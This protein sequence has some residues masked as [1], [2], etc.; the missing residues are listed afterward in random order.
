MSEAICPKCGETR[1]SGTYCLRCGIIFERYRPR[2]RRFAGGP[3]D[4]APAETDTP[5]DSRRSNE[6]FDEGPPSGGEAV[7]GVQPLLSWFRLS[8]LR[9]VY[10]VGRF[11]VAGV[12]G[13][14]LI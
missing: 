14:V 10:R 7:I 11:L 8:G 12:L 2:D 5:P 4:D 6:S 3:G 13:I 9:R 1:Q